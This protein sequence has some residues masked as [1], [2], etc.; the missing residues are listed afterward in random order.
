MTML[1]NIA[2]MK[3]LR[4]RNTVQTHTRQEHLSQIKILSH[5]IDCIEISIKLF[6]ANLHAQDRSLLFLTKKIQGNM[7]FWKN[8][9]FMVVSIIR[10]NKC[11]NIKKKI[12]VD[13]TCINTTE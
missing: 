9:V 5:I 8:P 2:E 11:T 13:T 7:K 10:K 6:T 3:T 1:N 4:D 12:T